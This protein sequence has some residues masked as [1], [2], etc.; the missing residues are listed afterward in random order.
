MPRMCPRKK[1]RVFTLVLVILLISLSSYFVCV[2]FFST[3]DAVTARLNI[4][5]MEKARARDGVRYPIYSIIEKEAPGDTT[6]KKK[7]LDLNSGRNVTLSIGRR[8]QRMKLADSL[9][10]DKIHVVIKTS[11]KFHHSRVELLLLTW[12]Q[13]AHPSNVSHRKVVLFCHYLLLVVRKSVLPEAAQRCLGGR[14]LR[15]FKG[16]TAFTYLISYYILCTVYSKILACMVSE[17]SK[18]LRAFVSIDQMVM[19]MCRLTV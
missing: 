2:T 7:E 19:F 5:M 1:F 10:V 17:S 18:K 3:N 11:A 9:R 12:L 4:E 14:A 6:R 16:K 8:P 13:T 15:E